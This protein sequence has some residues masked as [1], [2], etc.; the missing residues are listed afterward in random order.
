MDLKKNQL[1]L[2]ELKRQYL[3]DERDMLRPGMNSMKNY[4]MILHAENEEEL[5]M[6]IKEIMDSGI[7][8]VENL[9]TETE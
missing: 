2:L 4:G 3:F 6:I 8:G 7:D 1:S 5:D 9:E